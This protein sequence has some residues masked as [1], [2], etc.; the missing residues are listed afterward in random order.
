MQFFR[1]TITLIR[2]E[3]LLE[4]RQKYA[5]GGILLYVLATVFVIFSSFANA[6]IG[7][8]VW[9]VLYWII[10]LFTAVN[11]V[12]KSFYQESSARQL[13]YYTLLEPTAVIVSKIIYNVGLMWLISLLAFLSFNL[14]APSPIKDFGRFS[15][16]LTMG[17]VGFA[18]IFTF[19]SAIA[20]KAKNSATLMA[21][22]G[23]PTVI[24]LLLLLVKI[25][26]GA[27]GVEITSAET[28]G[29]DILLLFGID[30]ILIAVTIILFPYLWRE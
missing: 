16:A 11:A 17:G 14:V 10:I 28:F 18:I 20:T 2:K 12:A 30:L 3:V 29:K 6:R 19:I 24:P 8:L 15:V 1:T 21:I 23:F 27:I 22:L 5:I 9:N 7:P 13:Y 4:W 26:I 25:S